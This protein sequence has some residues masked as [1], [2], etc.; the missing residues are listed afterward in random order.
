VNFTDSE[1]GNKAGRIFY[2]FD[3]EFIRKSVVSEFDGSTDWYLVRKGDSAK[4]L[5]VYLHGHGSN[6]DQLLGRKDICDV[7][8][9][10]LVERNYSVIS[11][12]YRG[13]SWMSEAAQYDLVQIL[14]SEKQLLKWRRL[15][16]ISGSMGGTSNLIFSMHHTELVDGVGVMGAATD[17]SEYASWLSK[18]KELP[19]LTQICDA[20]RMA[21]PT[22]ETM[23]KNSAIHQVE[24]LKELPIVYYHGEADAVIPVTQARAFAEK[25]KDSTNFIYHEISGG[26]HDSPLSCYREILQKLLALIH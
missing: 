18:Q 6:A 8:T 25:L 26:N 21:F 4:P 2:M 9:R 23:K 7:A 24:Y 20:I 17:L 1:A 19:V 16:M 13:N 15:L 10:F 3:E 11:P 12:N 22:A 14:H 5:I